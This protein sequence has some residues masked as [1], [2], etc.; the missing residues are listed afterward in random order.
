MVVNWCG[1]PQ[2]SNNYS[3]STDVMRIKL[4]LN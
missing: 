2:N 4:T 3:Q 1:C